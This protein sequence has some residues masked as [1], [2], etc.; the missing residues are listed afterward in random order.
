MEIIAERKDA[1]FRK[2]A[3]KYVNEDRNPTLAALR[4]LAPWRLISKFV[5]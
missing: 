3:M 4:N 5:Y 2:G 1:R